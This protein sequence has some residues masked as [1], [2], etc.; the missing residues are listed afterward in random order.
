[1]ECRARLECHADTPKLKKWLI[2]LLLAIGGLLLLLALYRESATVWSLQINT[3]NGHKCALKA[4]TDWA[5]T[6]IHTHTHTRFPIGHRR[7]WLPIRIYKIKSC[8]LICY[9]RKNWNS[10][11]VYSLIEFHSVWWLA[12]T[13]SVANQKCLVLINTGTC[14]KEEE[15]INLH[16][17][18]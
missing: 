13:V 12:A 5:R 17:I 9:S 18:L 7:L 10:S 6:H 1:M 3:I 14:K 15:K 11:F 8:E 2:H 16:I 4:Q